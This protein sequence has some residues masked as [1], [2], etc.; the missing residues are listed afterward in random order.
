MRED[1]ITYNC[2]CLLNHSDKMLNEKLINVLTTVFFCLRFVLYHV[3]DYDS[4]ET[5]ICKRKI[6]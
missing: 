1:T 5:S 4:L 6:Y 3:L 2:T